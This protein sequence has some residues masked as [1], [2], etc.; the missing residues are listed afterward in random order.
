MIT[1]QFLRP[2]SEKRI[3]DELT[4]GKYNEYL[5]AMLHAL[6][7]VYRDPSGSNLVT[8]GVEERDLAYRAGLLT[9]P[10]VENPLYGTQKRG[11]VLKLI[12]DMESFGWATVNSPSTRGAYFV[13]LTKYG[14]QLANAGSQSIWSWLLTRSRLAMKSILP[15]RFGGS[16][17]KQS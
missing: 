15:G 6:A 12:R 4:T 16:G 3:M 9:P 11:L 10:E 14:E 2:G 1:I 17:E 5:A 13:F 7:A 8:N